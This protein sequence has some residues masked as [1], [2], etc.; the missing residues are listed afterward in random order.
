MEFEEVAALFVFQFLVVFARIGS[1][2]AF[3]PAFGEIQIPVRARLATALV[4]CAGLLPA[5]PGSAEVPSAP[6]R[7]TMV[8]AA[9]VTTGV[10]IGLVARLLLSSMHF[11]GY[12]AG[13]VSGLANA[14]APGLGSFE[15]STMLATFLLVSAVALLFLTDTHHVIIRALIYSY[16][17][18]PVGSFMMADKTSEIVRAAAKSLYIGVAVSAPFY[19]M[20]MVLNLGMGLANRMMP[21][22]PVFFVAAPLLIVGGL[23]VLAG[24]TP[25]IIGYFLEELAGWLGTFRF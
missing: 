24:A 19:V 13:Q 23:V 7:M 21:Q 10:W 18:F 1:A 8:L 6:M 12:Q 5:V 14:F 3:M 11:A 9:E 25:S 17:V 22:L 2:L 16:Q 4:V 15:G 20:G